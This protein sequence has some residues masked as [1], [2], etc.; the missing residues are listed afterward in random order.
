MK[1]L[2]GGILLIVVLGFSAFLYR[3][4]MQRPLAPAAPGQIACT[5]DAKVCPDG[6][7]VGR[8]GPRCAFAACPAPNVELAIGTSTIAFAL[9]AGYA[10]NPAALGPDPTLIGAYEK[11]ASGSATH[12]I[13]VRSYPI[14]AG[15]NAQDVILANTMF[16][17]SGLPAKA[18]DL[19]TVTISGKTFQSIV[20]ERF[21]GQVHSV[22]YL[23]RAHDVLRFEVL[24]RD[25][26]SWTDPK[27][28]VSALP[29]HRA[30]LAMLGTL[31]V[32]QR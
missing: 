11:P 13:V 18:A 29:E 12:A 8:S 6:T 10:A 17:P 19:K 15:K 2:L 16:E 21:E 5:L 14:P 28:N 30:F 3:N 24:E 22:Y 32:T 7:G 4:I 1:Q 20:V 27:L 26:T 31:Q 9:P 25:V 23:P